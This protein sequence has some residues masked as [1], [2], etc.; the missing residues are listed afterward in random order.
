MRKTFF[1]NKEN[2]KMRN[3]KRYF[4]FFGTAVTIVLLAV[5]MSGCTREPVVNDPTGT[6]P[7]PSGSN[8]IAATLPADQADA[9]A[10]NPVVAVTFASTVTPSDVSATTIILKEG[11][12]PVSGTVAYSGTTATFIPQSDLKPN[13]EYTATVVTNQKSGSEKSEHSW[14]FKTGKDHQTNNLSIV[15]VAPLNSATDVAIS[16]QPSATFKS[17]MDLSKIKALTF[18]LTQGTTPVEGT[19]T[20]SGTT[21][22]FVPTTNLA[23]NT[24]YTATISTGVRSGNGDDDHENDGD[25]EGD[26]DHGGSSTQQTSNSYSWSFTTGGGGTDVTAPTILSVV[27]A[28]DAT[29]VALNAK[30]TVT[31]SEAMNSSSITSSTFTLKQGM[32]NVAGTVTYSGTTATF[33]PSASLVANTVYT[34]AITTA[35]KDLAGNPL[36]S[37]YTWSFTTSAGTAPD[38][39]PPTVLSALPANNSTSAALNTVATVTF[40]EAMKA[41]TINSTTFTLKAGTMAVTGTV[42]YS[43]NKATFTPASSLAANTVYMGT[44]TTGATDVAGNAIA[45]NFTWSFTTTSATDVTP[46]T[47]LTMV[48]ANNATS[49]AVN[50]AVTATFSEAMNS[51]TINSSTFT[52]KQGTTSVAGTVSYSGTTATFTPSA[53]LAGGMVYTATITT[54]AQ[55]LAGNA[56]TVAK[57]WSFTTVSSTTTVSFATQVLPILQSKCMPCHGATSPTAGIS[58]TSFA[59]VSKLSNSQIDNPSMYPKMGVTAAEQA[60]IKAWIAAGRPNN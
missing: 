54:G 51:S 17:G 40:S 32:T 56:I 13:T 24:L 41:S 10:V 27:P 14:K 35:A 12:V 50:S 23:A 60:L 29:E 21:A 20:Y 30:P 42:A 55:D 8:L 19:I 31:F 43:G 36:A 7:T 26:G 16:V 2:P 33:T 28:N 45:S 58:I 53:A 39:T 4:G 9:V 59:T 3:N 18:T 48:P 25:H 15:S 57:T 5:F 47:V 37:T 1:S 44:I 38:V 34:G 22:T 52:L 49:I 46:P 11:T 6:T